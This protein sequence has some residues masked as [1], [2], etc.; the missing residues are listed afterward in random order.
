[1]SH[2]SAAAPSPND[3]RSRAEGRGRGEENARVMR[4]LTGSKVEGGVRTCTTCHKT[5]NTHDISSFL[6]HAC[7]ASTNKRSQDGGGGREGKRLR[8]GESAAAGVAA[9]RG[10]EGASSWV[11]QPVS[12]PPT[13][14]CL[15]HTLSQRDRNASAHLAG[16]ADMEAARRD[17]EFLA[18]LESI[19]GGGGGGDGGGG[20]TLD[21]ELLCYLQPSPHDADWLEKQGIVSLRKLFETVLSTCRGRTETGVPGVV[22][23]VPRGMLHNW[24][25]AHVSAESQLNIRDAVADGTIAT[26]GVRPKEWIGYLEPEYRPQR[27]QQR[28]Q[29]EERQLPHRLQYEQYQPHEYGPPS[30]QPH[31]YQPYEHEPSPSMGFSHA[32]QNYGYAAA[33]EHQYA[34]GPQ[35]P[36]IQHDLSAADEQFLSELE[37][38]GYGPPMRDGAYR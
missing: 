38:V 21:D 13:L 35:P 29:Q 23:A 36:P 28:Q 37:G 27:Q 14:V 10:V 2:V 32:Q 4:Q 7:K 11:G 17:S 1:M 30:Y 8:G 26:G 5:F 9:P 34:R 33:D 19:G 22:Y 3:A 24:L 31:P 18:S 12:L 15:D 20:S 6:R 16:G 25:R